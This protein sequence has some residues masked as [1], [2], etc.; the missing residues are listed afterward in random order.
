MSYFAAGATQ[1]ILICLI[2]AK[3]M[4]VEKIIII[5][6]VQVKYIWQR[7]NVP[8]NNDLGTYVVNY[9]VKIQ[10]LT[11]SVKMESLVSIP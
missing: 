10:V 7:S 6:I 3:Q 8:T 4:S 2:E 5:H 11:Q 1:I 9:E